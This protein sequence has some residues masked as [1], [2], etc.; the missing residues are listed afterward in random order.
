MASKLIATNFV[1]YVYDDHTHSERR[2]TGSY[3]GRTRAS[4][5]TL[6][7]YLRRTIKATGVSWRLRAVL[8][9]GSYTSQW[10]AK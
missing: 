9:Q 1:Y 4:I 10:I 3:L 2:Y 5:A 6:R 7:R 8:V